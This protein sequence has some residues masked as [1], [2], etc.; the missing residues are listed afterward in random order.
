MTEKLC[1]PA[2]TVNPPSASVV[3]VKGGGFGAAGNG[4]SVLWAGL[5]TTG[6]AGGQRKHTAFC[7]MVLPAASLST[8]RISYSRAAG[9][10]D[11]P[12]RK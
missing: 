5:G 11:W 2:R 1:P 6:G 3:T 10:L 8:A 4:G 7:A 12:S 9:R